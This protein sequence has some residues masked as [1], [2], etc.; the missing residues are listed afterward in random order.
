LAEKHE[1]LLLVTAERSPRTVAVDANRVRIEH[2]LDDV[3]GT[4]RESKGGK[5]TKRD[6]FA[7]R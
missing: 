6:G 2:F 4:A 7:V 1:P 5:Q 3:R